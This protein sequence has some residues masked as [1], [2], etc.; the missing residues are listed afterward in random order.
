MD[1]ATDRRAARQDTLDVCVLEGARDLTD[2][3][4]N[5]LHSHDDTYATQRYKQI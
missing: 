1:K 5:P 2:I 4:T 3:I